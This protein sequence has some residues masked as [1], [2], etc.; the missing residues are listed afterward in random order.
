M[1]QNNNFLY[2]IDIVNVKIFE[3]KENTKIINKNRNHVSIVTLSGDSSVTAHYRLGVGINNA[4]LALN[5]FVAMVTS[6]NTLGSS[7]LKEPQINKIIKE[8]NEKAKN[9]TRHLVQFE[10]STMYYESYCDYSIYFDR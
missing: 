3:A 6:L 4:F 10:L 2:D 7:N 5:E 1:K 9:R 8:K